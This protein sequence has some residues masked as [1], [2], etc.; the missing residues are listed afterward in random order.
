MEYYRLHIVHVEHDF[1]LQEGQVT[2]AWKVPEQQE[3]E[4]SS[5]QLVFPPPRQQDS[6]QALQTVKKSRRKCFWF[7]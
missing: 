7:L 2:R 4:Q 3:S 1:R 6:P 5:P